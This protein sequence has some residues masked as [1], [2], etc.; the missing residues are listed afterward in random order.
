MIFKLINSQSDFCFESIS[1][2]TKAVLVNGFHTR[3]MLEPKKILC[4]GCFATISLSFKL[5]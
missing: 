3:T 4:A 2:G 1:V 5:K